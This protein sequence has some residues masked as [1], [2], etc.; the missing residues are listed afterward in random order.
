MVTIAVH[1]NLRPPDV[2]PVVLGFN[3]VAH[4]QSINRWFIAFY[5]SSTEINSKQRA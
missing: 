2:V 1:C 5:S 3:Y 4:N